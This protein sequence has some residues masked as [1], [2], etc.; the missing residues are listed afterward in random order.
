M[1]KSTVKTLKYAVFQMDPLKTLSLKIA[2]KL[3]NPTNFMGL[4]PS[5][6]A[7]L[8]ASEKNTGTNTKMKNPTKLGRI[9]DRPTRVFLRLSAICLLLPLDAATIVLLLVEM[10]TVFIFCRHLVAIKLIYS[11]FPDILRFPFKNIFL[12]PKAFNHCPRSV[13]ITYPEFPC[14]FLPSLPGRHQRKAHRS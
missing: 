7:T 14:F 2:L 1:E 6:S 3:S 8:N 4:K 13:V 12:H 11:D 10:A 9:N 5:H